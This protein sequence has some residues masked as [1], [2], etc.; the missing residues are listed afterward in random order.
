MIHRQTQIDR[1]RKLQSVFRI[2]AILGPRQ[3][4]K[5][6]LA[7]QLA[8]DHYFDL[9]NTADLT[10]LE[11]PILALGDLT[12]TIVIDEIQRSPELF[13]VLRYLTD[14]RPKQDYIILGSASRDLIR[15]SSETLAGRIGF[16][17][18]YGFSINET[19]DRTMDALWTRGGFPRSFLAHSEEESMLWR[20]SF[21]TTFLERDIP[22]LGITIPSRTL[23]RFW[24]M[25]SNYNTQIL[26]FSELARSFGIS[27]TTARN[28]V[29]LLEGTFMIQLLRPFYINVPKRL[30]KSPKLFFNDTG[31]FHSLLSLNDKKQ[32]L[33]HHK[34]GASWECFAMFNIQRILGLKQE[35]VYF[36]ATHAGAEIDLFFIR[37]GKN[38]GVEFK[39]QDAPR[40]TRSL[41]SC[42]GDL[43]L[44]HAW[45]V[46][47][48]KRNY[49]VHDR[50]TVTSIASIDTIAERFQ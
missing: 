31:I 34:L 19:G 48:G 37:N 41:H 5:T 39:Y 23:R 16:H 36:Y 9:E 30:V 20:E 26:N 44:E 45:I 42:L 17:Y 49:P 29:E 18:L 24:M 10:A 50:V 6:T 22:Q 47:P 40:M 35:D 25:L 38:W 2:T 32:L 14:N 46:Y 13:P 15:Q 33:T 43:E 21:I 12:G 11:N 27:D 3:T 4:G 8:A 7:G 1:I 28:Y